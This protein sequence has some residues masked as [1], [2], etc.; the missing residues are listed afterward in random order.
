MNRGNESLRLEPKF[1]CE[2]S[3]KV[4]ETKFRDEKFLTGQGAVV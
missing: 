4:H 2:I 3:S 1:C